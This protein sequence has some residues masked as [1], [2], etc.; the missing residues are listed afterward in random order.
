MAEQ[1][2]DV[3]EEV[4]TRL[5]N[6]NARYKA[7]ADRKRREKIFEEGDMVMVYLRRERIPAGSYNKLKPKK[8]GPFKILKKINNNA[9]IVDLPSNMAM[10]KTFNV[11]DLYDYHPYKELYSDDNSRTSSFE[12]GGTDVGKD[13]PRRR[14]PELQT[15]SLSAGPEQTRSGV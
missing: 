9:Y 4:Q 1:V 2:H 11:A 13:R 7:I 12:E 6:S 8:Y 3:Q 15:R 5:E 14:S 10:S